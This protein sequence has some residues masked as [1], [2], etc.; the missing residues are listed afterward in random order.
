MGRLQILH[1]VDMVDHRHHAA[2][3]RLEDC[4]VMA[5]LIDHFRYM[6]LLAV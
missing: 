1:R 5:S 4:Y 3:R 2:N 6:F